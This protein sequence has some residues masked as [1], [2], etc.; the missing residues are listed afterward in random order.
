MLSCPGD[1]L[2]SREFNTSKFSPEENCTVLSCD[3][4]VGRQC[5]GGKIKSLR[6]KTEKIRI[7]LPSV[8]L[9]VMSSCLSM[10]EVKMNV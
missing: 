4:G 5:I 7:A 8:S 3:E 1:F 6:V 10:H 2:G 9:V